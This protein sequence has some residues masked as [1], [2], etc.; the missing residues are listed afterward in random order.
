ML[1]EGLNEFVAL[2]S[3]GQ[4]HPHHHR[5]QSHL[6]QCPCL[7]APAQGQLLPTPGA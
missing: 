3:E 7:K 4:G 6:T 5:L 2:E 1:T